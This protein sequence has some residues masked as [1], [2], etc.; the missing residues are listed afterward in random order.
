MFISE[1]QNRHDAKVRQLDADYRQQVRPIVDRYCGKCHSGEE[2]EAD[3]DLLQFA[4]L[5]KA[6]RGLR[7]WQKVAVA[8]DERG[9]APLD[10][11][12]PKPE[13]RRALRAWVG[14]YLD[15]EAREHAGDPGRVVMRRLS[16]VE[17]ANT[18]RDLTGV[19]LQPAREFPADGA[20]GEGFSNTGDALVMSPALL[21]KYLDAAKEVPR[22]TPS[23]C[24]T[25]SK[26]PLKAPTCRDWTDEDRR[27]LSAD[28]SSDTLD[29][30]AACRSNPTSRR[31]SNVAS[32]SPPASSRSD[33]RC[34]RRLRN[35]T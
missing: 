15:F 4:T 1:E 3:V 14:L 13:E 17:Y 10:A 33:L 9:D 8:L 25:A 16:N 31:P 27:S 18:I 24:P 32:P 7:T 6:R 23:S 26:S 35:A 34:H 11:R 22:P 28:S 21:T 19:D 29:V 30:T 20:A 2:P 5:E 12:Q